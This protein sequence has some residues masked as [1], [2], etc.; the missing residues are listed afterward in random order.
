MLILDVL[1]LTGKG[2][3]VAAG[4]P[5]R[6]FFAL[7]NTSTSCLLRLTPAGPPSLE[8]PILTGRTGFAAAAFELF[9][10]DNFGARLPPPPRIFCLT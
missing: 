4:L 9:L 5:T 6:R 10:G 3:S 7:L 1:L 8:G 2:A